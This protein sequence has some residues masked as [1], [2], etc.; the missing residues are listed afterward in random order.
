MSLISIEE[1]YELVE[2]YPELASCYDFSL[3]ENTDEE[4]NANTFS[5]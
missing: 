2:D 5:D 1:L 4:L 3:I